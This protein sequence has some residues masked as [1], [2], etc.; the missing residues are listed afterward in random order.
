[1]SNLSESEKEKIFNRISQLKEDIWE[2]KDY[3]GSDHCKKCSEM[4]TKL[5]LLEQ[6][7]KG[8]QRKISEQ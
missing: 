8:L 5:F 6:E 7:L 2:T 4:Y 1:M 3:I